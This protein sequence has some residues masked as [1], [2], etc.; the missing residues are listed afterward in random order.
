[1]FLQRLLNCCEVKDLESHVHLLCLF[2]VLTYPS[3]LLN[4]T[5]I[6]RLFQGERGRPVSFKS[7]LPPLNQSKRVLEH[8]SV[9]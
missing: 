2:Y 3:V 8:L 6:F 9:V 1:M 7:Y 5:F 4:V